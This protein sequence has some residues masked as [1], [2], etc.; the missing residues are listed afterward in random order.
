MAL[1]D[2]NDLL[3]LSTFSMWKLG[4]NVVICFFM[5]NITNLASIPLLYKAILCRRKILA[6]I[7]LYR[8]C[9]AFVSMPNSFF[10]FFFFPSSF[11]LKGISQE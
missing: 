5:K 8:D 11:A 6:C 4:F 2:C 3:S 9:F 10:S 1:G 7:P